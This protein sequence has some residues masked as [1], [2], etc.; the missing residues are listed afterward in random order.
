MFV[1]LRRL[2][3]TEGMRRLREHKLKVTVAVILVEIRTAEMTQAL[4][5]STLIPKEFFVTELV[6]GCSMEEILPMR[7][8]QKR[9][10]RLHNEHALLRLMLN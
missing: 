6:D 5:V 9:F 7:S 3:I 2:N 8:E 1:E 4:H 10:L